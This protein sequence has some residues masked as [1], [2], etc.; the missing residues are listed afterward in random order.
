MLRDGARAGFALGTVWTL[1]WVALI[2][3]RPTDPAEF[4]ELLRRPPERPQSGGMTFNLRSCADCPLFVI[5]GRSFAGP[6]DRVELL[7]AWWSYPALWVTSQPSAGLPDVREVLTTRFLVANFAQ[8]FLCGYVVLVSARLLGRAQGVLA[9]R[10]GRRT[11][12]CS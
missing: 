1:L 9:T 8:W 3:V 11:S 5:A 2:V 4:L 7:A 6:G 12:G 10:W